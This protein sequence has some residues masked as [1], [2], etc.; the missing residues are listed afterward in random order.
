MIGP[1]HPGGRAML[2]FAALMLGL[3]I[4]L[5]VGRQSWREAAFWLAIAV[6]MG[7]YGAL[8]LN[9]LPRL[10]RLLLIA[11]LVAGAVAFG[12]ALQASFGG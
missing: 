3:A 6:F 9:A 8:T 10:H 2:L 5:G 7:C 11:G 1:S 12:L 4:F